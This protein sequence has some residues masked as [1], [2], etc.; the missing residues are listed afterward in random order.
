MAQHWN[1]SLSSPPNK[2]MFGI[3]LQPMANIILFPARE[4]RLNALRSQK[5]PFRNPFLTSS[6]RWKTVS[7]QPYVLRKGRTLNH[8]HIGIRAVPAEYVLPGQ[9][10]VR[11]RRY[12]AWNPNVTRKRHF[13]HYP[14]EN[15][16]VDRMT[17]LY[18]TTWGRVKYTHDVSRNALIANVLPEVREDIQHYDLWRYRMEHVRSMEENRNTCWLRTKVGTIFPKSVINPPRKPPPSNIRR[19]VPD[20]WENQALPDSKLRLMGYPIHHG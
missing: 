5:G 14:G 10:I 19:W 3:Q 16:R 6:V 15:I 17:N 9:L 18:S 12:V 4:I 13:K 1:P 7:V 20:V 2:T 11:Q 8:K